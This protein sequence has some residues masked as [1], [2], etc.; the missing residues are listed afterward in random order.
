M[1][2]ILG[3]IDA[4]GTGIPLIMDDYRENLLKPSIELSTN[5][6]RI[7]LPMRR[8]AAVDQ[9]SVDMIMEYARNH[10]SFTRTEIEHVTGDSRSKV[11]LMLSSL[12]KED[13]IERMGSERS[14]SYRIRHG[15]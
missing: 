6:F 2:H 13:L 11:G 5:V 15:G 10:E 1:T 12:V 4:L 7:V 14:T 8:V 3:F 9:K